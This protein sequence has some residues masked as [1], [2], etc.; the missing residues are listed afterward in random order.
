M[1][2]R[3]PRSTLFPY[4]T[5]FRS[6]DVLPVDDIGR[7]DRG[8]DALSHRHHLG[9]VVADRGDHREL[10]AAEPRY[11]VVAAQRVRQ[12]QRDV[13]DQFV[14]YGVAERVVDVLEMVEGDI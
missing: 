7:A 5:L 9:A 6:H 4:T 14:A 13:A 3:P 11:Q 1:I 12:A 2:R 10:V 8:D